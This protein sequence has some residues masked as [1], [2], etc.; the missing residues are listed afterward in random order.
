M[1]LRWNFNRFLAWRVKNIRQDQLILILSFVTGL[2]GGFAAILLKNTVHFIYTLV[3][4]G[5][6][7]VGYGVS[8]FILP[9]AGIALTFLYV[10]FL[11]R[12]N[13]GHGVTRVLFAISRRNSQL[14]PHNNYTSVV[15]SALTVGFGGSVGLE[16]PIVLTGS[17]IGSNLGRVFKLNYKS[18][19]LLLACGAAG[20][21]GG[22]FKAPIAAVLFALEV[23]MLDLT[24]ASLVPLLIA[25]VTGASVS[26]FFMGEEVLFSFTLVHPFMLQNIPYY[27]LLGVFSGFISVYFTRTTL[28][29]EGLMGRIEN[30]YTKMLLGGTLAGGLIFL[31]PP[32][33]GEGYE[34]LRLLLMGNIDEVTRW[35]IFS[36]FGQQGWKL[37]LFL[38]FVLVAKAFSSSLTMAGGGVGGIFAPTLFMGGITGYVMAKVLQIFDFVDISERNFSLV[39]M[40]AMMAGVMHAPMT[41]IFLIAEI[42]GGYGL[43]IP[44]IITATIAYLTMKYFEPHSIY[45]KR[46]ARRGELLTHNKDQAVLTLMNLEKVVEKDLKTIQ[47]EETLGKLVRLITKSKRNIFPVVDVDTKLVGIIL[48][49]DVREIIFDREMYDTTLARSLMVSPPATLDI[50][51]QMDKVMSKFE[52]TEAWNLPVTDGGRYVGFVS[53]SKLF[54][55]YRKWLQELS[56]H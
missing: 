54:M 45:T 14:T 27:I 3:T 43:F 28:W 10:R 52:A 5:F 16:A 21:I 35:G 11:V 34:S 50:H 32:L 36:D 24:M 53:K 26:Y 46:L 13:I 22:I 56:D 37:V 41:A 4:E 1:K 12:D 42:T 29:V 2:F 17:S 48:L 49:D 9:F 20:A 6:I 44:L 19:T 47:P 33:F 51:D 31:L 7:G 39:G 38:F 30:P 18:T 40:A 8:Y 55:V 25:A 23:L 15:G